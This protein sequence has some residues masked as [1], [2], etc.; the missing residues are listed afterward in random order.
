MRQ[1]AVK[2]RSPSR[3][4]FDVEARVSGTKQSPLEYLFISD[5]ADAECSLPPFAFCSLPKEAHQTRAFVLIEA[6]PRDRRTLE[7]DTQICTNEGAAK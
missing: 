5:A 4:A 3:R 6:V 1:L 2:A 7:A